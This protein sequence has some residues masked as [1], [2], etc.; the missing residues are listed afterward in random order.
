MK[1]RRTTELYLLITSAVIN[2]WLI[3]L[4]WKPTTASA[5]GGV[6]ATG[7]KVPIAE[8]ER[9]ASNPQQNSPAGRAVYDKAGDLLVPSV[10]A[11]QT[12]GLM[13]IP[14]FFLAVEN[15]ILTDSAKLRPFAE[16]A[17]GLS[18]EDTVKVNQVISQVKNNMMAREAARCNI[19]KEENGDEYLVVPE[20]HDLLQESRREIAT[21]LGSMMEA[22][23]CE[24]AAALLT[25]DNWF[26]S[27]RTERK[28]TLIYGTGEPEWELKTEW[29]DGTPDERRLTFSNEDYFTTRYGIHVNL[30]NKTK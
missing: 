4:V 24:Y 14:A 1:L 25:S 19:R 8:P 15:L 16:S 6:Q 22:S 28:L 11:P 23:K 13:R 10:P 18:P 27:L 3:W 9:P 26:Q 2:L 20:S 17:L 7:A 5:G 12:E 29:W 30:L 21:T